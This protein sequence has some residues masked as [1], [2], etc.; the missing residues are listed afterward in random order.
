MPGVLARHNKLNGRQQ[1]SRVDLDVYCPPDVLQVGGPLFGDCDS[2][3]EKFDSFM[4]SKIDDKVLM[5]KCT[6]CGFPDCD[7]SACISI[8]TSRLHGTKTK[9]KGCHTCL[10]K[11]AQAPGG[12]APPKAGWYD[13]EMTSLLNIAWQE[14][15]LPSGP[16]Y[17]KLAHMGSGYY[18]SDEF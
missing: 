8:T 4:S 2:V 3:Q 9:P 14:K 12:G 5:N 10:L 15:G 17:K 7:C 6:I 13:V 16:V 1:S 18:W 11:D